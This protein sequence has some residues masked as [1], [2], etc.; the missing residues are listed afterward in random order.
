MKKIIVL[1]LATTAIA[2]GAMGQGALG[3][4]NNTGIFFGDGVGS[5]NTSSSSVYVGA[6]TL[7]VF[8]STTASGA[9]LTAINNLNGTAGGGAAALAAINTDGFT[10]VDEGGVTG[11]ANSNSQISGFTG[12]IDLSSA[13]GPNT[14][15][16][17]VLYFE[18]TGG[19]AGAFAFTGSYGGEQ[20]TNPIGTPYTLST[21]SA[22]ETLANGS[23]LALTAVPEPGTMALAGL[24]GLSLFFFRRKK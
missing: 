1:T 12:T 20:V 16:D 11:A 13:F 10:E 15:G 14:A 7:E 4:I 8:F 9:D 21:D 2:F 5:Q 6:L 22:L 18:G 17:I 3:S 23:N 24:G 19:I